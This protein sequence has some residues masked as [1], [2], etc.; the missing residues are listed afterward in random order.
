M[1]ALSRNVFTQF[2]TG[3]ASP[4]S[5][6]KFHIR[7]FGN[8]GVRTRWRC[9]ENFISPQCTVSMRRTHYSERV[10]LR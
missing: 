5:H 7:G 1:I 9:G 4:V 10:I 3:R 2:A 8:I 6:T